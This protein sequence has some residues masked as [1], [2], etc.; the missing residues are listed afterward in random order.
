[1]LNAFGA[2]VSADNAIGSAG[3]VETL[4]RTG[5]YFLI[6]DT[7]A[8]GAGM[9]DI[10]FQLSASTPAAPLVLQLN[11]LTNATLAND[12]T[13]RYAFTTT[14]PATLWLDPLS[15]NANVTWTIKN[16][17]GGVVNSGTLSGTS[18][19]A[20]ALPEGGGLHPESTA[21]RQ[22]DPARQRKL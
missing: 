7:D 2:R 8:T 6:L 10:Q 16:P 21:R 1:M 4:P 3:Q 22:R 5:V 17:S 11:T 9:A 20:I 18:A 12:G 15:D 13:R 19:S 14:G